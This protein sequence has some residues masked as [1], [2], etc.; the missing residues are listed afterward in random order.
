MATTTRAIKR[1][2]TTL[3]GLVNTVKAITTAGLITEK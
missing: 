1:G 2:V 3:S